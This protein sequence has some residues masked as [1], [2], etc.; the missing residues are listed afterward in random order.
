MGNYLSAWDEMTERWK[1]LYAEE[2][3]HTTE[4]PALTFT[5]QMNKHDGAGMCWD[6]ERRSLL[7]KLEFCSMVGHE[8]D[9]RIFLF[10]LIEERLKVML[11]IYLRGEFDWGPTD[12]ADHVF[13]NDQDIFDIWAIWR[14]C[15]DQSN[16]FATSRVEIVVNFGMAG[17]YGSGAF[18]FEEF[19]PTMQRDRANTSDCTY[20]A[21][22]FPE[23]ATR[24]YAL[25]YLPSEQLP[26]RKFLDEAIMDIRLRR[27][28]VPYRCRATHYLY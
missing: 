3:V 5:Q 8:A 17:D 19:F 12:M 18:L 20:E 14:M 6:P 4:H 11:E 23:F 16:T 25:M 21:I 2:A 10:P 13:W 7:N 15:H 9:A 26:T 24:L 22:T 1:K 28:G 27:H